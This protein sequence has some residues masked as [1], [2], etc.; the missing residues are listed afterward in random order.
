MLNFNFYNPTKIIFGKDTI[1]KI[2]NLIPESA[3][4]MLTYGG[5]SIK[6]N[7]VY[8]QIIHAL[9]GRHVVEFGGI[10]PNPDYDTC[11]KAVA[12]VKAEGVDFLL[13]AGGGSV[14]DGT[15]FIAAAAKYTEPDP[16]DLLLNASLIRDALPLGTVLTLPGTGS[17]M[18]GGSVI[19]R[20]STTEKLFF[21]SDH[22]FP[23]FSI[24]D[25]ETTFTLPARQFANGTVDAFVQVLEQY[26]TYDVDAPLQDR[27][28]EGILLTLI[29]EAPKVEAD[30]RNYNARANIMWCATNGLN[31]W[32]AC[33]QPQDWASHMIGHE[34]TAL[35]GV[36][37]GQS[38]AIVMPG[39]M[40]HQRGQKRKKLLQYAERV[41][42]LRGEDESCI[43]QA[44]AKT[45][46]FFRSLGVGT[47]LADYRIP[48][49]SAPLVAARLTERKMLLGEHQAIGRKE[50]EQILSLRT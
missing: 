10:E 20:H 46:E 39:V 26:L 18:N 5:G 16:W 12:Q 9:D 50:V 31:G 37:H 19:S 13:A 23:R 29:Q 2:K 4:V 30:P 32:I 11:L 1:P 43:D 24:L 22:T 34:L 28:S 33:G 6:R 49:E 27:F 41:W 25:P 40:Q 3:K 21:L 15:K 42:G 38:L 17:E 8:D 14:I 35:Y 45:E 44:I 7:G 47:R 48:A 36:D